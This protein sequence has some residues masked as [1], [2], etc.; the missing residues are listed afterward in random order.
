MRVLV[1]LLLWCLALALVPAPAAAQGWMPWFGGGYRPSQARPVPGGVFDTLRPWNAPN[2]TPPGTPGA[3]K[4]D[5]KTD[6]A[7]KSTEIPPPPYEGEFSRLAEILGA[8][9]YLG[10]LCGE[11]EKGR[12]RDEMQGLLEAEQPTADRRDRL[13]GNFNR[14]YQA[15]EQTYRN[16]TAAADLVIH[17][18]LDEGA[19]LSRDIASRYGN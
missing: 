10:P 8:L 18:F 11:K 14:G 7:A 19:R 12:W 5:V 16:C 15:Y 4:K 2:V 1:L 13:V 17:R 6:D 3:T 9:H